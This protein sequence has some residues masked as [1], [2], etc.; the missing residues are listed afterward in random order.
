MPDIV[1]EARDTVVYKKEKKNTMPDIK[2]LLSGG[3]DK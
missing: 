1:L 3:H 2:S